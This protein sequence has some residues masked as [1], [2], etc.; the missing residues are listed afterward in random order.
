[1]SL[2]ISAKKWGVT[3]KTKHHYEPGRKKGEKR[4]I[5]LHKID[6]H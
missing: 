4:F 1:M 5:L 3:R 2:F 6:L